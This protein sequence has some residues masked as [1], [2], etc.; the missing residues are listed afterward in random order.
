MEIYQ[1]SADQFELIDWSTGVDY[2]TLFIVLKLHSFYSGKVMH[3]L[4]F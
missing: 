4:T 3:V 1:K 2:D